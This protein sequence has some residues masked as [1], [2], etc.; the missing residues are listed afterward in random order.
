MLYKI[1]QNIVNRLKRTFEG[2]KSM[3]IFDNVHYGVEFGQ[4]IYIG[5]IWA[6]IGHICACVC[7]IIFQ[8]ISVWLFK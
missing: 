1:R 8:L 4:I 3:P 7:S 5:P 6:Y 2:N